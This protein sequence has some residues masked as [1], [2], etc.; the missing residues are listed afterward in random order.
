MAEH[1]TPELRTVFVYG[2]LKPGHAR[3]PALA[4]FADEPAGVRETAVRGALWD[5]GYGWPAM[6]SG[7]APVPGVLVP[8]VPSRVAEAL[9]LLDAIEGVAVG[10]FQRVRVTTADGTPCWTYRWPG[11]TTDFTAIDSW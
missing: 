4:P 10:L 3:W 8:L 2:T 1:T 5:T 11:A 7:A 6:T 9:A